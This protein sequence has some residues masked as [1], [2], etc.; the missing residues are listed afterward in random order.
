[1]EHLAML[2]QADDPATSTT[3]LEGDGTTVHIR[4]TNG[5]TAD[6][7]KAAIRCDSGQIT[8]NGCTWDVAFHEVTGEAA[9]SQA[10]AGCRTKYRQYSSST[11]SPAQARVLPRYWSTHPNPHLLV[12]GGIHPE[13]DRCARGS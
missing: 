8:A 11:T 6:C 9:L 1:M 13:S 5:R 10:D 2:D 7:F 3:W 12:G 4:S